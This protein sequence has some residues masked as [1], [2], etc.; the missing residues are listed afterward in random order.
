ML[1]RPGISF[2]LERLTCHSQQLSRSWPSP[3]F[4]P[5][6]LARL[7]AGNHNTKSAMRILITAHTF[8]PESN[9]VARVAHYMAQSL[10][11]GHNEV[12]VATSA[13]SG[14]P[15]VEQMPNG[16]HVHRF[17]VRGSSL[18]GIKGEPERYVSFI[19]SR[20]WDVV[21]LNCAQTW[22]SDLVTGLDFPN[23]CLKIF[24]SHGM[25]A[26]R[27]A[28]DHPYFRSLAREL[29]SFDRIV[30]LSKQLEELQFCSRF[31]L[32][33]P[34]II[35]NPVEVEE[36]TA[37]P[38]GVRSV[39][40]IGSHP[41]L[42]SVSNHSPVKGHQ[43]LRALVSRLS[44][45]IPAIRGS[46]IGDS[47][48]AE[49]CSL[50]ELGVQGGCWYR[51]RLAGVFNRRVRL[52]SSVPRREVVSAIKEA[53]IV[54]VSSR[55]EASPLTLL[56]AMAA[57]TP[58]VS[59]RVG[60]VDEYRGGIVVESLSDMAAATEAILLDSRLREQLR[61]EGRRAVHETHN[62]QHV[63]AKYRELV[64]VTVSKG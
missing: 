46:I 57:G 33:P 28:P 31:S 9:G 8:Y 35:P 54:V 5:T 25:S 13:I 30:A 34:E 64:G 16:V 29:R 7:P 12:H 49:R 59:S 55:R 2:G 45:R 62:L 52:H 40:K 32:N 26:Y 21:I 4:V 17:K 43:M 15:V 36:F 11:N 1:V 50:G 20:S 18:A 51:C 22:S 44:A 23:P 41:W 6:R 38:L 47:Y 42:L 56:E 19:K 3:Q 14:A 27:N 61:D 24:F 10:K 58:W 39:W 37:A 60:C 53:D 48:P 63:A